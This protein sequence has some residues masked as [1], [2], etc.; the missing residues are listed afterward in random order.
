MRKFTKRKNPLTRADQRWHGANKIL[1]LL[2]R[3]APIY[4]GEDAVNH[5]CAQHN[6]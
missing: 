2:S 1:R 3:G 4:T 5:L 6:L